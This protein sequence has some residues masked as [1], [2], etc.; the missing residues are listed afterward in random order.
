MQEKNKQ[1]TPNQDDLAAF[2]AS[3][4]TAMEALLNQE[5]EERKPLFWWF[6]GGVVLLF[7]GVCLAYFSF[8]KNDFGNKGNKFV[9]NENKF[10]NERNKF[11]ISENKPVIEGN[12]SVN[13][14]NKVVISE[15]KVVN[16]RNKVVN[17]G[18]KFVNAKNKFVINE[19][20]FINVENEFVNTNYLK[21]DNK[22][23]NIK[24]EQII[25]NSINR[26]D[27]ASINNT[28]IAENNTEITPKNNKQES[29][30][31]LAFIYPAHPLLL[32]NKGNDS[33]KKQILFSL[34]PD[35]RTKTN[36]EAGVFMGSLVEFSPIIGTAIHPKIGVYA[37]YYFS[38]HAFLGLQ[39][40]YLYAFHQVNLANSA[41]FNFDANYDSGTGIA[42]AQNN[43]V[44]YNASYYSQI[45]SHLLSLPLSYGYK[46][47]KNEFLVGINNTFILQQSVANQQITRLSVA[48]YNNQIQQSAPIVY[49]YA[50]A[51]QVGYNYRF[52]PRFALQTSVEAPFIRTSNN[53]NKNGFLG[54]WFLGLGAS[55][56]VF[57]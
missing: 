55:Y 10:V 17:K 12:K 22:I 44:S 46:V 36:W 43:P 24:N 52:S 57:H 51:L 1:N 8:Y 14:R 25:I 47:R 16:E 37:R 30:E 48:E 54:E 18:N 20:I 53:L 56:R 3:D 13:E 35:L 33:L 26:F 7:V 31:S 9:I 29:F 45:T 34:P 28:K 4:W 11:V 32:E 38:N 40:S 2:R 41:Q 15:N 27:T 49:N 50:A 19:E 6:T 39:P 5:K 21:K 23:E 42:P